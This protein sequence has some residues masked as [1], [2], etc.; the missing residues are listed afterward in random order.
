[1][2][3]DLRQGLR[4]LGHAPGVRDVSLPIDVLV[5][6]AHRRRTAR[7]AAYGVVGAGAATA[8]AF[9]GT[10]G[11]HHL[12][13]PV[14]APVVM[15]TQTVTPTT[16]PSITPTPTPTPTTTPTPTPTKSAQPAG[17]TP[18]WDWCG[19]PMV[20]D[21][22]DSTTRVWA[23]ARGLAQAD[24]GMPLT[25]VPTL[26]SDGSSTAIHA[27]LVNVT[28]V[29]WSMTTDGSAPGQVVGVSSAVDAQGFDG[30]VT[31]SGGIELPT[32]LSLRACGPTPATGSGAPLAAGRYD[33]LLEV[34][35]T[36]ATGDRSTVWGW[37]PATIGDPPP[38]ASTVTGPRTGD[39]GPTALD[40]TTRMTSVGFPRCGQP[41][42]WGGSATSFFSV[43]G[44]A[45][46][47]ATG[48]V[49]SVVS[50]NTGSTI[51]YGEAT[52]AF[53]T[54]TRDGI[55]VAQS[56]ESPATSFLLVNWSPGD[57]VTRDGRVAAISCAA[58][59]PATPAGAPLP[60][61]Q[62]EVWAWQQVGTRVGDP[63]NYSFY[64]GP[65]ALT[66]P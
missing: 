7:V 48:I 52:D 1:M 8:L 9:G 53:L 29:K 57:T 56:P 32:T 66:I 54:V 19:R 10:A 50:T 14:V 23:E 55:V 5:A 20:P 62:Y 40:L 63:F 13:R 65:W 31:A 47:D 16:R 21:I 3:F 36:T 30:I 17:W 49:A 33:L 34:E 42:T 46:L 35:I 51:A 61:G 43:T 4:E 38:E 64:G 28:V 2:D 37:A 22:T 27:R 15:P 24:P 12:R 59:D 6:R 44:S 11:L 41:Y 25:V 58:P 26:V 60:A 45:R 39:P 18:T